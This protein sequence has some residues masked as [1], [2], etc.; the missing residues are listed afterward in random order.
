MKGNFDSKNNELIG[1]ARINYTFNSH[2]S[3]FI[4][5]IDPLENLK[6]DQI[7]ALL[8]NSSGSSSVILFSHSAF[9]QLSKLSIQLLK[10]HSIKL[11][12]II[13]NE[14]VRITNTIVNSNSVTRFPA[15][16]EMISVSLIKLFKE[17]SE[18]THKFVEALIDWNISY[19][20]T[21]HP[22]FLN[23]QK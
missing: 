4:N 7:R 1:G 12:T 16:N 5:M 23:G 11:V 21:R 13:F 20:S 10:P 8:Y 17:N 18:S 3:S 15:L 14:L 6:D 2:F 19:I 9:E 22:D